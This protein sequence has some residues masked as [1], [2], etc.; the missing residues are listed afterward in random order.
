[1]MTRINNSSFRARYALSR[2]VPIVLAGA[3]L[4]H[5]AEAS[6]NWH[7]VGEF[8]ELYLS[9]MLTEGACMIDMASAWQQVELKPINKQVLQHPG[10]TGEAVS[11][12]INLTGCA[13][14]GG[15]QVNR[16]TGA[17]TQDAIQPVVT[18]S[19]MG[20]ADSDSPDLLQASGIRGMGLRLNDPLGRLVRLGQRGEPIMLV[21]GDNILTYTVTPVRTS[22]SLLFG[23]FRAV[24]NFEVS[25]D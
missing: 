4:S 25:Y 5:H 14:S 8:G 6:D 19:F 7:V 11:F 24:A 17:S 21:P 12:K 20:T 16:Y 23:R 13:R 2:L 15:D 10:D 9:G 3:V 22:A 1:M 18:I